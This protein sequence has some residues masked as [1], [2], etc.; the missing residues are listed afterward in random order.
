MKHSHIE[1][2]QTHTT[3]DT[4]FEN[5]TPD[6]TLTDNTTHHTQFENETPEVTL[7]DNTTGQKRQRGREREREKVEGKKD[8][9]KVI[10]NLKKRMRNTQ[11]WRNDKP[12]IEKR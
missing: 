1:K 7:T 12:N 3:H 11:T 5:E 4:Q 9:E 2:R 10:L 8:R 6:V